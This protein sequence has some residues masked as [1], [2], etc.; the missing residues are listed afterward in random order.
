VG[1]E[2]EG[3]VVPVAVGLVEKG[4]HLE[5]FAFEA[6]EE[7]ALERGGDVVGGELWETGGAGYGQGL[8]GGE[9]GFVVVP[10]GLGDVGGEGECG[11]GVLVLEDGCGVVGVDDVEDD[12]V[13]GAVEVVVVAVPVGG[14]DVD[15]DVACPAGGAYEEARV[16][17]VGPG[18]GVE[19]AGVLDLHGKPVSGEEVA[20]E[21]L[22]LPDVLE[23]GFVD[24]LHGRR[25]VCDAG[26]RWC[27]CQM[28]KRSNGLVGKWARRSL[29]EEVF[30]LVEEAALGFG[31]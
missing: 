11:D 31:G 23:E 20:F 26:G 3:G 6:L 1:E 22:V 12:V 29:V 27:E 2:D 7:E 13:V 30:H 28:S 4:A 19:D 15:F 21:Q 24:A 9:E 18:M 10:E 5:A 8:W 14:V 17:E 25:C 16:G